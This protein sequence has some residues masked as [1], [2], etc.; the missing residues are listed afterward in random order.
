MTPREKLV[1]AS[2]NISLDVSPF[3]NIAGYYLY[4][5][6]IAFRTRKKS[7]P[8]IALRSYLSW[9]TTTIFVAW[10]LRETLWIS[11]HVLT[12]LWILRAVCS[13]VLL[14]ELK[15]TTWTVPLHW[16]RQAAMC[17]LLTLLMVTPLWLLRWFKW[18]LFGYCGADTCCTRPPKSWRKDSRRRM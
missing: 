6:L 3:P 1:T 8:I 17:S 4:T 16:L 11:V 13:W 18:L 10:S 9:T 7:S 14:S 12:A 5:S 15:T 2:P